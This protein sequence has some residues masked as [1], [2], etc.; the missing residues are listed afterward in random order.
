MGKY[1]QV[2][3]PAT[4]EWLPGHPTKEDLERLKAA[5]RRSGAT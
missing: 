5:Q 4:G 3:D 2:K 1:D